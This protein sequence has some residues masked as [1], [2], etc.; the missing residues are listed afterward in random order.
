MSM[1]EK[2]REIPWQ[3]LLNQNSG[4]E[5]RCL[6]IGASKGSQGIKMS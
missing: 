1:P 2:T 3:E 5:T 4:S 6:R